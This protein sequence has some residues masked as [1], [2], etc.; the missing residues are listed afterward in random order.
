MQI[1]FAGII[2]MFAVAGAI[3]FGIGGKDAAARFIDRL[4]Q[5]TRHQ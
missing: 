3:A 4:S 2:G 5:D 1:M